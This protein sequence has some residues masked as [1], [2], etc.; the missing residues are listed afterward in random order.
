ML[1]AAAV[2]HVGAPSRADESQVNQVLDKAIKAL[3]DEEKLSK[4]EA[5]TWKS[6]GK[7]TIEGNQIVN[8]SVDPGDDQRFQKRWPKEKRTIFVFGGPT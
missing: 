1:L 6:K 4:A 5:F 3:G 2:S 7:I 8:W